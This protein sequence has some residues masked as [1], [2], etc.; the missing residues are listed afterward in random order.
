MSETAIVFDI[1]RASLHDG[2]GIRTT[3]FLKGCPLDCLWCHNPEAISPARQLFFYFDKCT[4]CGDCVK[5]C[6]DDVHHLKDGKHTINY[7]KCTFCGKCVEA[8]NFNALKIIGTAMSVDD[9]MR[10]IIADIDFYT[11]SGGGMTLSGGEPL[12]NFS[13]S[14]ELLKRCREMGINT[15]VETSGFISEAKFKKF[16]PL[17]DIFLFDYKLTDTVEHKKYT[18]VP[19]ERILGNLNLAYRQGIPII[20]RCIVVPGIN[21]TETHFKGICD[22]NAKYPHLKDIEILPYH[23][24]GNNKRISIGIDETLTHLNTVPSEIADNWIAQLKIMGCSKAK[25]G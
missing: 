21:D 19:N 18:G 15:C 10:E 8:C 23:T 14:M 24:M 16:L 17:V 4:Q 7:N 5:V 25:I 1:Q 13:F 22:L 6:D 11:N 9:V 12:S 3:I 2:P 20:L